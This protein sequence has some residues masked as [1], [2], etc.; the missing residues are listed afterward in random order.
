MKTAEQIMQ[1]I[2]RRIRIANSLIDDFKKYSHLQ[3]AVL[4]Y[5]GEH[6]GLLNLKKEIEEAV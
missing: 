4:R 6:D 1:I 5:E 2:E 3:T